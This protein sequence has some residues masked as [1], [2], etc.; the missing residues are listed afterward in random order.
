MSCKIVRHYSKVRHIWYY[1]VKLFSLSLV[2]VSVYF[3]LFYLSLNETTVMSLDPE[4][5]LNSVIF[6]SIQ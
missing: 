4:K 1:A 3:V 5:S 2:A 6:L